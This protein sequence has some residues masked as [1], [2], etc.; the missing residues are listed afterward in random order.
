MV[1]GIKALLVNLVLYLPDLHLFF[2]MSK[3]KKKFIL[4][5]GAGAV[6]GT[7]GSLLAKVKTNT[8]FFIARGKHQEAINER[9]LAT[10][11]DTT[12]FPFTY[13]NWNG[14]A[15]TV[16]SKFHKA[17]N[18]FLANNYLLIIIFKFWSED[19]KK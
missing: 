17:Y 13:Q 9:S 19:F 12:V 3:T 18:T 1:S 4:I 15:I 6:G 2:Y 11:I 5:M 16:K 10:Y 8:V 14:T 7:F